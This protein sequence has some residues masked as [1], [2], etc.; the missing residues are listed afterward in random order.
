MREE[1][2][3]GFTVMSTTTSLSKGRANIDS[4]NAITLLLLLSVGNGVRHDETAK[5]AAVQ[6]LNSLSGENAVDDD[7]VY[8][9]RAVLHDSVSGLDERTAGIS[10]IVNDNCDLV[11]DISDKDH[12]GN[13]IG[14]STFFVDESELQIEAVGDAGSTKEG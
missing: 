12:A 10:H 5:T 11:L 14:A 8:F 4:L 6:V 9:L 3:N 1:E 7:S 2:A 13:L